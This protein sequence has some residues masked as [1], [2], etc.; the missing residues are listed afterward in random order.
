MYKIVLQPH[1]SNNY[2]PKQLY[3][4]VLQPHDNNIRS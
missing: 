4:I 3:K 1:D 2:G